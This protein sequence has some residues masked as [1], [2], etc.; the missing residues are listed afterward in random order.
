M[1]DNI[2]I[3]LL[4]AMAMIAALTVIAMSAR[5]RAQRAAIEGDK[6]GGER[7][8]KRVAVLERIATDPA[9][10]TAREIENLR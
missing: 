5:A 6:Q 8:E 7:L 2:A 10:R 9:A 4:M 1:D 3:L